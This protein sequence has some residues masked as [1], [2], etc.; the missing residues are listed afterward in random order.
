MDISDDEELEPFEMT[1]NEFSHGKR[2]FTKEDM[3]YGVWAEH[4]SDEENTSRYCYSPSLCFSPRQFHYRFV[5]MGTGYRHTMYHSAILL[6]YSIIIT[7]DP[8][9][10]FTGVV[11][12]Q[13]K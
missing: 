9:P 7:C 3:I 4:N 2:K 13:L 6:C 5:G 10:Y 11:S 1:G 8:L 12:V